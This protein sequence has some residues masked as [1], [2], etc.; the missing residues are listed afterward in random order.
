MVWELPELSYVAC[1]SVTSP[2]FVRAEWI[3]KKGEILMKSVGRRGF[4]VLFA[5]TTFLAAALL[6]D[7][8]FAQNPIRD[9]LKGCDKE[10][11][12]FC[13]KVTPGKGRL[14]ACAQAHNDKLSD[15]CIGSL[16]RAEFQLKDLALTLSYIATQCKN[17]AVKHCPEVKLGEGRVLKC[18]AKN[19]AKISKFCDTALSDV[20]AY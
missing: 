20:G 7:V 1:P 14:V 2:Y 19:K 16:N 5:V 18:L 9:V 12:E 17:D 13:N 11:K 10:I 15:Q 4:M 6:S 8:S 3:F